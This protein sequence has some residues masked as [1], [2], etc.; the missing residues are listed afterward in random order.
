[1]K[2]HILITL[3][4]FCISAVKSQEPA[5]GQLIVKLK[6]MHRQVLENTDGELWKSFWKENIPGIKFNKK[7]PLKPPVIEQYN[8]E[9]YPLVDLSRIYEVVFNDSLNVDLVR[10]QLEKS[11]IFEYVEAVYIPQ[12]FNSYHVPNDVQLDKQYYL[13]NINAFR[14]WGNHKGDS[15]IIL[16]LSDTG[17][18]TDHPDLVSQI[19]YNHADTIDGLDNDN[20]GYVDNYAGWDLGENDNLPEI[21][22]IG[23]GAHVSGIMSADPDN[24]TGIAGVG[25]NSKFLPIKVDDEYGKLIMA[26]ESIVYAA[27]HGCHVVNCSWGSNAGAG[28]YGQ[29]IINYATFNKDMLVVAAVGNSNNEV[30]NYPAA[31]DNVIGVAATNRKDYKMPASTFNYSVD[32]SAPGQKVYSTW[33]NDNYVYSNGTSMASPMVT[34]AAGLVRSKYPAFNAMQTGEKLRVNARNFYDNPVTLKYKDKLGK[35]ILDIRKALENTHNLSVRFDQLEWQRV[36]KAGTIYDTLSITGTFTNYLDETPLSSQ[37]ILRCDHPSVVILDSSFSIN[38]L[39]TMQSVKNTAD[40]FKIMILPNMPVSEKVDFKIVYKYGQYADYQYFHEV[41]NRGYIT[42]STG[43]YN[44]TFSSVGKIGYNDPYFK[45]GIGLL[46][47][48]MNRSMLATG[49]LIVGISSSKVSDQIYGEDGFDDDFSVKKVLRKVD[50]VSEMHYERQYQSEF[51]DSN[52]GSLST[53]LSF[54]QNILDWTSEDDNNY[55]IVE[56]VMRNTTGSPINNIYTGYYL[57]WDVHYA[58][59]N[60]CEW[61]NTRNMSYVYDTDG[62]GV[63]GLKMI[64]AN[65]ASYHYAFDNNGDDNSLKISDGFARFEKWE[66][67]QENRNQAGFMESRGNDVSHMISS[68][69]Y[70]LNPGDSVKIA[71]AILAGNHLLDVEKA[72][73]QAVYQYFNYSNTESHTRSPEVMVFPNPARKEFVIHTHKT[74]RWQYQVFTSHGKLVDQG[75]FHNQEY[76]YNRSLKSGIYFIKVRNK[77]VTFVRKVIIK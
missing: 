59:K 14:G 70:D 53:G 34:A 45:Q 68:G 67:M 69:P 72:A 58:H 76:V 19:A 66:A 63:G 20:D 8:E 43:K 77:D 51:D 15:T 52:A 10:T 17:T 48:N 73:D 27:D 62:Y 42:L 35:G 47:N 12:L 32:I 40:P 65:A 25:Y 29:D 36:G 3:L 5:E 64:K 56:Y 39:K 75:D 61:D 44:A 26:Y 71:Y 60:K 46:H 28:E 54:T 37:A 55:F 7:F 9:G 23:H 38:A 31:Y 74:D 22:S 2:K 11:G 6:P 30:E 16:G 33:I 41:M 21:N 1:M 57:D 50:T 13:S 18:D 49:G 4:I 24:G